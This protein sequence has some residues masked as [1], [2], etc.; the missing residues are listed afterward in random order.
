MPA[1]RIPEAIVDIPSHWHRPGV[2]GVYSEEGFLQYVAAESNVA[3]A[4]ANHIR[5]VENPT[6]RFSV[7]MLTMDEANDEQ[8]GM[9]AESWV[10][11]HASQEDPPPG[12]SD[13][14]PE[15]RK[16]KKKYEA[17][18]YFM[19]DT[20]EEFAT[21]EIT[22]ILRENKIVLFMKGTRFEPRCGFSA[23]VVNTLE[24]TVGNGFVCVDCLDALRNTG[25]RQAI[26]D[27]SKWPTIP[28]LY[29]D[30][31]FVGG[32][33]IVNEMTESGE[34]TKICREALATVEQ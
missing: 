2:Y 33:D 11:A 24:S 34:L 4:I 25:L 1:E 8:L 15:W 3:D 30:G 32:A 6:D 5:Y 12:N 14:A 22:S 16:E 29:V 31:D 18:V 28:Q 17:N 23:S 10:M 26:K 19:K 7:R 9:I 20:P 27:F 13:V 21:E